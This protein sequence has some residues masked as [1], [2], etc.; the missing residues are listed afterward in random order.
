MAVFVVRVDELVERLLDFFI[1]GR[2]FGNGFLCLLFEPN[3]ISVV[4]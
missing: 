4:L 3:Q 1:T 2:K